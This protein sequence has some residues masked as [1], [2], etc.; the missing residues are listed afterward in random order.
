MRSW[1]AVVSLMLAVSSASSAAAQPR[2]DA[3]LHAALSDAATR[4]RLLSA[5][6]Q[7]PNS[8]RLPVIVEFEPGLLHGERGSLKLDARLEQRLFDK[9]LQLLSGRNGLLG[10][11]SAVPAELEVASLQAVLADPAIRALR[12]DGSVARFPAPLDHTPGMVGADLLRGHEGVDGLGITGKGMIVCDVDSGVDVFHPLFFQADGGLF[13]WTDENQNGVLDT[14]G[15]SIHYQ[16]QTFTLR[17]LNGVVSGYADEIPMFDTQLSMLDLRYDY[18][19]AD[20]NTDMRRNFGRGEGFDDQSPS[21]GEPL[22]VADDVNNNGHVDVGEKIALLKTSKIRA[23]RYGEATFRRGE[24]LI[25]APWTNEMQ[26]GNGAAGILLGG[27]VGLGKLVGIAPDAELVMATHPSAGHEFALTS[28]CLDEGARVVLHEY[29]PWVTHALDGSSDVETLIDESTL[30]GVS[31]VNPAGNLSGSRKGYKALLPAQAQ[32]TVEIEVPAHGATTMIASFLWREEERELAFELQSPD[33][34]SLALAQDGSSVLWGGRVVQAVQETSSRGTQRLDVYV[35]GDSQLTSGRWQVKVSE[36]SSESAAPFTLFGFVY[37]NVSGWNEGIHF[38]EA[39]SEEHLI[40]W[41]AT[42][43]NGLAVAAFRGSAYGDDGLN[44]GARSAYSGRGRRIDDQRVLWLS[45]PDNPIVPGRFEDR[46]LSYIIYGGT[47]G[48]SPH[49][50]GAAA[51]MFSQDPSLNG[52]DVKQRLALT[53]RGDAH[54]GVLPNEDFGHGKLDVFKALQGVAAQ[55]G[56]APRVKELE[57]VAEVGGPQSITVLIDDLEHDLASLRV[58]ADTDYDGSFETLLSEGGKLVISFNQPELRVIKVRATD[59]TGRQ[60][61][62]LIRV[63]AESPDE[64]EAEP[65]NRDRE[66]GDG[67]ATTRDGSGNGSRFAWLGLALLLWRRQRGS[68]QTPRI[69]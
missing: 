60:G 69:S 61:S 25:D 12:L 15:D 7:A 14:G 64:H 40:G 39:S 22:F 63:H 24:N 49:V 38:P 6:P 31:H 4:D 10:R 53:A 5:P 17:A 13:E 3:R 2:V 54:T 58:E 62:G 18:F 8:E 33:G 36:L 1:M 30:A 55:P 57:Y 43:D 45:A 21:L 42:A 65:F 67:C 9:G 66:N 26:H 34:E 68:A 29:A 16:G 50:A 51:L 44:V 56:T 28:F 48:A 19:Y 59:P 23:F 41:P 20:L 52:L 46:P 11:P 27:Q 47:S 32:S 37:D 35:W